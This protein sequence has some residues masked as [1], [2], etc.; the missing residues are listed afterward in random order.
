MSVKSTEAASKAAVEL[1]TKHQVSH[2][3]AAMIPT[4]LADHTCSG[5]LSVK[6][7]EGR[8]VDGIAANCVSVRS[9]SVLDHRWAC[10]IWTLHAWLYDP[11]CTCR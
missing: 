8:A 9:V 10:L 6:I 7:M 3:E 4:L 11:G 2:R 5:N 1:K